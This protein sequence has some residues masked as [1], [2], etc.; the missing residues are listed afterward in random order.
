MPLQLVNGHVV[1]MPNFENGEAFIELWKTETGID[2]I[3][4]EGEWQSLQI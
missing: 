4:R 2:R 3:P 1:E